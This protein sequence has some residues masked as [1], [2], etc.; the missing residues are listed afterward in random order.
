MNTDE[1]RAVKKYEEQHHPLPKDWDKLKIEWWLQRANHLKTV[2][3][4]LIELTK[5][6]SKRE[7]P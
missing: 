5:Y 6:M 3:D 7:K 1:R 2:D 4:T